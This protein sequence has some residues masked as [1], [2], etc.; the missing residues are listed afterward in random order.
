MTHDELRR[1]P[2]SS[3][4]LPAYRPL[5]RINNFEFGGI[6]CSSGTSRDWARV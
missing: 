5:G 2:E 4:Q 1:R 6:A 3:G